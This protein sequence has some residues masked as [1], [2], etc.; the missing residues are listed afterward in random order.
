MKI[1]IIMGLA[2]IR[3]YRYCGSYPS[4]LS[5]ITHFQRSYVSSP[6]AAI[7]NVYRSHMPVTLL[8]LHISGV[9]FASSTLCFLRNYQATPVTLALPICLFGGSVT[10]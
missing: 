7:L 9:L 5:V 10:C 1:I 6:T 3:L 2:T 8:T 4:L